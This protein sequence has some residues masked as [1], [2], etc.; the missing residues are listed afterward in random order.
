MLAFLLWRRKKKARA[1]AAESQTPA[2]HATTEVAY[3][4]GGVPKTEGAGGYKYD[5][6]GLGQGGGGQV[7][8]EVP[9]SDRAPTELPADSTPSHELMGDQGYQEGRRV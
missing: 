7:Y 1:F 4:Y 6:S 2:S 8:H 5:Q 3:E 9:G